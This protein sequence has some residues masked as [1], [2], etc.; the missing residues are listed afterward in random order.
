[1]CR[2]GV[3]VFLL[4]TCLYVDRSLV[5]IA[6]KALRKVKHKLYTYYFFINLKKCLYH[7]PSSIKKSYFYTI[8]IEFRFF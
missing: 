4:H 7:P 5:D 8:R 3:H 1:M 2:L 6:P